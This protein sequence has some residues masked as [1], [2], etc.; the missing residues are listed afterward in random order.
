MKINILVGAAAYDAG[1]LKINLDG[2]D[3]GSSTVKCNFS[4]LLPFAGKASKQAVDFFMISA[5]VYGIDRFVLRRAN[6]VDGWS[7]ELNVVFPVRD[8]AL[9][10]PFKVELSSLLS[11]LTGDYWEVDFQQGEIT[12]PAADLEDRFNDGLGQVNLFSGGL[13]S[14]IGAIKYLEENAGHKLVVVSHYD[15]QM[16]G[17]KGDQKELLDDLNSK[18]AGRLLP[19]PSVKVELEKQNKKRETTFRSRS[20]LFIGLGGMVSDALGKSLIVPE[21]GSVS[22]NYPLSPSRRSA[23]STRTTHPKVI[24]GVNV[25]FQGLGIQ[26]QLSNPFEFSTKGEMVSSLAPYNPEINTLLKSNSCGKRRHDMRKWNPDA[27][28]CG[29]CMP[30]IYRR[31]ALIQISA[32]KDA[33]YGDRISDLNF[34]VKKG[35]DIAACLAFLKHDL[36]PKEI[37]QE[38]IINGV[39]DILKLGPYV[40]LVVRTR[41]ELKALFSQIGSPDAKT[42]AGI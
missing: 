1:Q 17:P 37:K 28:H 8:P 19:V 25:L 23:C 9:W 13:D 4:D 33:D 20:I 11:F 36:S 22:L 14:L 42:R 31:A 35:Q 32:D 40:A 12:L 41:S 29:T 16:K 38:L 27:K 21:N 39:S 34:Y 3:Y 15:P 18:Y 6:S 2:G 7:R 10:K 26:T 5:A 30:C 24:D